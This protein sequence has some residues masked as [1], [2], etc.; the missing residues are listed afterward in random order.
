MW[1]RPSTELN[2]GGKLFPCCVNE[3]VIT[4]YRSKVVS[5]C[6]F[7]QVEDT[8]VA[9]LYSGSRFGSTWI[10]RTRGGLREG[11]GNKRQVFAF[12]VELF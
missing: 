1:S 6:V 5:L 10:T 11:L 3:A 7:V 2:L 9:Q 8:Q 12:I 4:H